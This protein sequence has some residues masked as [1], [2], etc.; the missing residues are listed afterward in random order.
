MHAEVSFS[1]FPFVAIFGEQGANQAE[2]GSFVREEAGDAGAAF[3]FQVDAFE[4]VGG[5]QA[6]LLGWR[7]GKDA[8]MAQALGQVFLHPLGQLG[9]GGGIG[10]DHVLEAQFGAGTVRAVEDGA[11]GLGDGGALIQ[12]RDVSLDGAIDLRAAALRRRL[13][14]TAPAQSRNGVL[15]Q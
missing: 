7:E 3:E 13:A 5:A 10:G 6:A 11:H 1:G 14:T 15:G 8:K 4:G 9:R 2:E 12:A